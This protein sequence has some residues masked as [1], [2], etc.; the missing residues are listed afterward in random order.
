MPSA[1][2]GGAWQG[3][4]T[5][6]RWTGAAD[7]DNAAIRLLVLDNCE[8]KRLG[9]V[10]AL[11]ADADI[12]VVGASDDWPTALEMLRGG[13]VDV[14]IVDP[15]VAAAH[16]ALEELTGDPSGVP[17]V[18][19]TS[20]DRAED[21]LEAVS[22]GVRGYLGRTTSASELRAAIKRVHAGGTVIAPELA[23]HLV[24]HV[25]GKDRR[26]E[27]RT[28]TVLSARERDVL[29]LVMRGHTQDEI[30]RDLEI[31]ERTVQRRWQAARLALY[32]ALHGELPTND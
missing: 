25:R 2:T 1:P 17:V 11:D 18:A 13:R 31:S 32:D 8:L 22:A 15:Q 10:T 27:T 6:G 26:G 24:R 16:G 3:N 21:L 30:A 14:A 28:S 9:I 19:V 5:D 12:A 23:G 20:S 7:A 29:R 4:A